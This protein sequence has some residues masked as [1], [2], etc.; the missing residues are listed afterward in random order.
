MK[1]VLRVIII[2]ILFLSCRVLFERSI[3]DIRGLAKIDPIPKTKELI[4][5]EKYVDAYEYLEYFFQ[6][7]YV[8]E[9]KEAQDLLNEIENK[10]A[11]LSYQSSKLV[12]GIINGISDEAIGNTSAIISDFFLFG[13]LR[14]L[15]IQAIKYSNNEEVDE[16][17]VGLSAI[18]VIATATTYATMEATAPAKVGISTLKIARRSNKMPNWI[19][20]YLKETTPIIKETKSIKPI[21]KFLDSVSLI[22]KE[23]NI[24]QTVDIISK[25]K[26]FSSLT[27]ASK[28]SAKFG[29]QSSSL[30]KIAGKN[31]ISLLDSLK[32]YSNSTILFASKYGENGL[33]ALSKLG[34]KRFLIRM[35]KTTYKGNMDFI[36]NYLLKNIPSYILTILIVLGFS[37][38]L[39]L[40]RK[41]LGIKKGA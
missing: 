2:L 27:K 24:I 30:L 36:Y 18:G 37:Y 8:S 29:N 15:T 19:I 17:I 35:T 13:D 21:S 7:N 32:Y 11:K 12:E 5:E 28:I 26:D 34:T 23:N 41:T 1:I 20:K 40:F 38:F 4:K 33:K 31:S 14:D 6:F 10:R 9:N 3:Y 16:V 25:T 39:N 22:K